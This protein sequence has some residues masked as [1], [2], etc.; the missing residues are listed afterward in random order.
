MALVNDTFNFKNQLI[1][2]YYDTILSTIKYQ[3]SKIQ[4]V[5]SKIKLL[6]YPLIYL[7]KHL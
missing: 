1:N 3:D 5:N 4:V 7:Q 2:K 6:I